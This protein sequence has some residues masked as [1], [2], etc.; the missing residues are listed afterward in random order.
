MLDQRILFISIKLQIEMLT[1]WI[2]QGI[3]RS[4][5]KLNAKKQKYDHVDLTYD[6]AL[7][8]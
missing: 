2:S 5:N 3:I 1:A 8:I 7:E 6:N 4:S